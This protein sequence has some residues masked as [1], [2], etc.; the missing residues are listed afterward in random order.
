MSTREPQ[1]SS[2]AIGWTAFAAFGLMLIGF[3]HAIAGITA[4]ANDQFF[5]LTEEYI[6]KFDVTSWGWVHLVLGLVVVLAGFG[7]F[8]GAVWARTVGVIV[9]G[10]SIILNF[11]A[12]VVPGVVDRHDHGQLLRDLGPDRTWQG[13]RRAVLR[14]T[15]VCAPLLSRRIPVTPRE[16][17][18]LPRRLPCH[19]RLEV[20]QLW[21]TAFIRVG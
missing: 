11:A 20:G 9:A 17:R 10:L 6:F 5:V 19:P 12:A 7:L 21:C 13:Y 14:S 8:S 15:P 18:H 4:I 16:G 1:T 2:W 3:F